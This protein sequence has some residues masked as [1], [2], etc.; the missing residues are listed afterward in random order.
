M[1]GVRMRVNKKIKFQGDYYFRPDGSRINMMRKKDV[2]VVETN[3]A[4]DRAMQRIY[5]LYGSRIEN[6]QSN[7][8]AG[9]NVIRVEN[10]QEIKKHLNQQFNI[11]RSML[12]SADNSINEL[13]SVFTNEQGEGDVLHLWA[14][15]GQKVTTFW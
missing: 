14:C 10:T 2:Y 8:L 12:K 4:G 3:G 1:L 9:K 13:R 7:D 5:G 15:V 11:S 6:I